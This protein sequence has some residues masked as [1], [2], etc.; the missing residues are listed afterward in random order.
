MRLSGLLKASRLVVLGAALT[1]S[2]PSF[3]ALAVV[4]AVP[5]GWRLQNYTTNNIVAYYTGVTTCGY[6]Q[7]LVFDSSASADDKNRFW[8]TIMTGK[9]AGKKVFV[10]YD[11]ATCV[12]SS[13]GLLE[14]G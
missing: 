7:G 11:D 5:T 3:A 13:F 10:Y 2:A 4:Y 1:A 6:S 12:I 9:T 8:T 14:N